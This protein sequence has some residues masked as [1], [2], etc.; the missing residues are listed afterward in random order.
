MKFANTRKSLGVGITI[1][2]LSSMLFTSCD[3]ADK[4]AGST[5]ENQ[6]RETCTPIYEITV[7]GETGDQIG[8]DW[9]DGVNYCLETIREEGCAGNF[10]ADTEGEYW[11]SRPPVEE[12]DVSSSSVERELPVSS[13]S[14]EREIPA[15][16]SSIER[17]VP[18]SSSSEA[19]DYPVDNDPVRVEPVEACTPIYYV[20]MDGQSD[21]P[22][23]ENW[24]DGVD[25]CLETIQEEGCAGN[26]CAD[27]E[28][29]LW[30]TR[31]RIV[32]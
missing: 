3:E 6:A 13:S 20:T 1:L 28:G 17:E 12:I 18:A 2:G 26:F 21:G 4:I 25:Y 8:E 23:G 32:E 24:N 29:E 14:V 15:S 22:I 9:N 7:D 19:P 5:T 30:T 27:T 31:A 10:C 16:S 11:T